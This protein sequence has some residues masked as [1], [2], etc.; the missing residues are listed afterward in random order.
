MVQKK[1]VGQ[2]IGTNDLRHPSESMPYVGN[3]VAGCK[4]GNVGSQDTDVTNNLPPNYVPT[5]RMSENI[6]TRR[7]RG[8]MPVNS[9][10]L[11]NGSDLIL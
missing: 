5:E 11:R 6:Q 4:D 10:T 2:R 3:K 8:Q 1:E 9:G 7:F